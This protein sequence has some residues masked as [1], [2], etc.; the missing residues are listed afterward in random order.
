MKSVFIVISVF[1]I[2]TLL[3]S[4]EK[5]EVISSAGGDYSDNN[6][7]VSW[8]IGEPVISTLKQGDFVIT[9]GFHQSKYIVT[10]I[11]ET[12]IVPFEVNVFPNPTT[13]LIN[14]KINQTDLKGYDIKLFDISG[15]ILYSKNIKSNN[16]QLDLSQ[17]NAGQ[18]ILKVS[19]K[20]S[21]RSFSI[22]K[23]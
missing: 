17:Y 6:I 5:L 15:K 23:M 16:N 1:F 12:K 7:S 2:S 20:K 4:Q 10:S 22:V 14:V 13:D 8:T 19:N 11:N 18:Y 3:F 21:T 9:Q